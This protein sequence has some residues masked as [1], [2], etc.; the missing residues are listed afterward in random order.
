MRTKPP[1]HL[2]AIAKQ[3]LWRVTRRRL[4]SVLFSGLLMLPQAG[5]GEI[6]NYV[7]EHGT[8]V[9]VDDTYLSPAE[10]RSLQ[11]KVVDSEIAQ[12]ESLTTPVQVHGNQVLVPVKISDGYRQISV[13]LLLDTGASQT[14][15]HRATVASL[16]R[17]FL[18]QGWSRL[19]GGQLIATEKVRLASLQVGPY[20]W[21][22]PAVT[23]IEISDADVPFE[24]LL[25]M[26][27]LR[28]HPYRI[29]FQQQLIHWQPA[30]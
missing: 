4:L 12:R 20:T 6:H 1:N 10:R 16:R 7:D 26:D 29:D 9:F 24:G 27:F 21:K 22:T 2:V 11:Q 19:A 5:H 18:G 25:G 17:K 28:N 8:S 13:R 3:P 15:F 30:D 23:L 14:V